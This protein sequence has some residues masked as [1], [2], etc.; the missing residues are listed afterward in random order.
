MEEG[1]RIV[2]Y[3]YHAQWLM[4]LQTISSII[5]SDKSMYLILSDPFY[6]KHKTD[7]MIL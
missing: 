5:Q 6:I 7:L 1:G 3:R 2:L 4:Y